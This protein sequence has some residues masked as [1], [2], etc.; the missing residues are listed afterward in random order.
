MASSKSE[1]KKLKRMDYQQ[2]ARDAL[3]RIGDITTE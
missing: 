1:Y 2:R 3:L